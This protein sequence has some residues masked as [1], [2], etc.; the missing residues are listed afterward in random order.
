MALPLTRL[1]VQPT[2]LT[3]NSDTLVKVPQAA[4]WLG[5]SR[6]TVYMLMER[7]KL[8]YVLIGRCRRLRVSDL[9]R[10]VESSTRGG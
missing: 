6:S 9:I 1:E 7:G 3:A 5:V 8:P 10:L 2:P 4:E